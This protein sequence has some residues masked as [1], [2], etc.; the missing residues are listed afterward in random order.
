MRPLDSGPPAPLPLNLPPTYTL[1]LFY[2]NTCKIN[3]SYTKNYPTY[4][5]YLFYKNTCKINTSYVGGGLMRKLGQFGVE[6]QTV[7]SQTVSLLW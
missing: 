4:T 7:S 2:K 5:L 1:Y 3:T 6:V